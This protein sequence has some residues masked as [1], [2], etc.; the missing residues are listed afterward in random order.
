MRRL[1]WATLLLGLL[2]IAAAIPS[3]IGGAS[4]R[5]G[6]A[7]PPAGVVALE[8]FSFSEFRGSTLTR[9]LRADRA[10]VVPKRIGPFEVGI[11]DELQLTNARYEL[12]E[13]E[14]GGDVG[15]GSATPDGP[16]R[17]AFSLGIL[18]GAAHA[19]GASI[20]GFECSLVRGGRLVTRFRATRGAIDLRTGDLV[21]SDFEAEH[22]PTARTIRSRRAVWHPTTGSFS[23][24][25]A[26]ELRTGTATT[27]GT[28]VRID[29]D[30]VLSGGA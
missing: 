9:R 24:R 29:R 22:L 20:R 27:T 3:A 21:L 12:F 2:G 4:S 8:G 17:D 10:A 5:S 1:V 13:D 30:F 26:F 23:I 7:G 28:G 6:S 16:R 25:G 15:P 19:A 14:A 11:L 18:S